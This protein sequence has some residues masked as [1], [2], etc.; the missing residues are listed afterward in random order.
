MKTL[1]M[2]QLFAAGIVLAGL[3]NGPGRSRRCGNISGDGAQTALAQCRNTIETNFKTA[4]AD[5]SDTWRDWWIGHLLL[6]EADLLYSA[7]H[8]ADR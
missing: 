4:G 3:A 5:N 6:Q 8:A 2:N 1:K 7:P